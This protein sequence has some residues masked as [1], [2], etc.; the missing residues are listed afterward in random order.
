[1]TLNFEIDQIKVNIKIRAETICLAYLR[2]ERKE[3]EKS[4]RH[5]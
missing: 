3:E 4:N 5:R 1:L 2:E